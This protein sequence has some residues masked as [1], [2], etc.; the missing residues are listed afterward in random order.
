MLGEPA[1]VVFF[2]DARPGEEPLVAHV[3]ERE[4]ADQLAVFLQHR[5]KRHTARFWQ[6]AGEDLVKPCLRPIACDKEL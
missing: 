4:V 2:G 1:H 3:G 5:R 6:L